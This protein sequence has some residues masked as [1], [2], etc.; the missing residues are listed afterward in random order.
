VL[1]LYQ[2]FSGD[3]REIR[4]GASLVLAW[5]GLIGETALAFPNVVVVPVFDLFQ[6]RPDRLA[7]DRFHPNRDGYRAIADRIVQALPRDL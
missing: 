3:A 6:G 5:S 2:P 1:D 4:V 7:S